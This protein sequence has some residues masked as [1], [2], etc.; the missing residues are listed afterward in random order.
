MFEFHT[1]VL[2]SAAPYKN[3]PESIPFLGTFF[4]GIIPYMQADLVV[5]F[6]IIGYI[7]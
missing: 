4:S 1:S 6:N 5:I 2:H 7:N 3:L